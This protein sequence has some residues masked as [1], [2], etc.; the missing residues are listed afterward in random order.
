[1]SRSLRFTLLTVQLAI[2]LS[3]LCTETVHGAEHRTVCPQQLEAN[4]FAVRKSP[5]GWTALIPADVHMANAGMLAGPAAEAGYL[6]PLETKGAKQGG[7]STWRQRWVFSPPSPDTWLY[8]GYGGGRA[9]LQLFKR[10]PDDVRQ[11]TATSVS[12]EGAVD[13]IVF[14]CE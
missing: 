1:M 8:C 12:A 2:G 13:N 14:V 10:V 5:E 9:P 6:V 11:C 7:K 3:C 4:T